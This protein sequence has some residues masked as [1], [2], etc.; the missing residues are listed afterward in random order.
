MPQM[1]GGP[2]SGN[3]RISGNEDLALA[4]YVAHTGRQ[5]GIPG[6]DDFDMKDSKPMLFGNKTTGFTR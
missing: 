4:D 3:N 5:G 1:P 2:P 6:N